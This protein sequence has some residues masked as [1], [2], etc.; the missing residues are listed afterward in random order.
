MQCRAPRQK[1]KMEVRQRP[2]PP[3]SRFRTCA[4]VMRRTVAEVTRR[5]PAWI[6]RPRQ[7]SDPA[8][9]DVRRNPVGVV[10]A[11]GTF[12]QGSLRGNL[13]LED[14]TPMRLFSLERDL[15][16]SRRD[17]A[18]C[19]PRIPTGFRPK[20]QGCEERATL[21]HRWANIINRNAV[22]AYPFMLCTRRWTQP[23]WR[24][25]KSFNLHPPSFRDKLGRRYVAPGSG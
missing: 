5:T 8:V 19:R 7:P 12:T 3:N 18:S 22:A 1:G 9:W 17:A 24:S 10:F 23:L 25:L 2:T 20:A 21:G 11:F 14:A 16:S 4:D 15:I 13:G 6:S